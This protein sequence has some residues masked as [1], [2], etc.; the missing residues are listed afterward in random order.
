NTDGEG[1]FELAGFREGAYVVHVAP[2]QQS[3][4]SFRGHDVAG[5]RA[6]T[7]GLE[8]AVEPAHT[9]AGIVVDE[10]GKPLRGIFVRQGDIAGATT[11][12][13]GRFLLPGSVGG[14]F[15]LQTTDF[16]GSAGG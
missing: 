14:P 2:P 9:I 8:I 5:V 4:P 11:D 13:E 10:D 6:G 7:T 3:G 15:V 12:G 1:R 16:D